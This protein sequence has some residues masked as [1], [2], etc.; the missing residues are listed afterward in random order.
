MYEK[1]KDEYYKIINLLGN[2]KKDLYWLFV[3]MLLVAVLDVVFPYLNK[4][5]IDYLSQK[6]DGVIKKFRKIIAWGNETNGFRNKLN[7][8]LREPER[9][10]LLKLFQ[11]FDID[12]QEILQENYDVEKNRDYNKR[13][14]AP[15]FWTYYV[16]DFEIKKDCYYNCNN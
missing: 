3:F 12:E 2:Q 15:V 13:D 14:L 6:F 9:I 11:Q 16:F 10:V 7:V 1:D 4:I 5:A 8:N